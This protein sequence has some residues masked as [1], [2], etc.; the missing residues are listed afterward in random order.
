MNL[1]ENRENSII[2][3]KKII[4]ALL[5][6]SEC[7]DS[8]S[9][10]LTPDMFYN[11][12]LGKTYEIILKSKDEGMSYDLTSLCMDV[13][14]E[15]QRDQDTVQKLLIDCGKDTA[16]STAIEKHA[17][18]VKRCYAER[19]IQ[20]T[21]LVKQDDLIGSIRDVN[22]KISM[23]MNTSRECKSLIDITDENYQ[24]YFCDKERKL[25]KTGI[26]AVD[27]TIIAFEP[28]DTIT[29]GARPAVG[30]SAFAMQLVKNMS[31]SGWKVG[32]FNL[33]MT[34][35]QVFERLVASESGIGLTRIR[36]ALRF[37]N[38]EEERY[39]KALDHLRKNNNLFIITGTTTVE[40]IRTLVA[41]EHFDVVVIDY[42]QLIRPNNRYKGNRINEVGEISHGLKSIATSYDIPVIMLSQLNRSVEQRA[43]KKP[44]MADLRESGDI[45]QDSSII[46][47]LWNKEEDNHM[48][49]GFSVAKDRNGM[50][51]ETEL[52]FDGDRMKFYG[53]DE[54]V[55][56]DLSDMEI[57]FDI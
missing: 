21:L 1:E 3:E 19:L 10:T 4:G 6:D 46:M 8:I 52:T 56:S 9:D 7:L 18:T 42:M 29:I 26:K 17:D 34:E 22:D 11:S 45:E 48:K 47:F 27:D 20:T 12:I 54:F 43:D 33:E 25:I 30:K 35:K 32:Y 41:K 49:K 40:R 5:I 2:A 53:E 31:E 14:K 38:D 55:P 36:K 24:N 51:S 39:N 44:S 28:G 37:M 15:F 13:G 57:P 16:I 23:F 50:T